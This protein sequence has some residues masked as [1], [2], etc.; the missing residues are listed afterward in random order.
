MSGQRVASRV[1][2]VVAAATL[3]LGAAGGAA[4]V[5]N[6]I[7]IGTHDGAIDEVVGLGFCYANGWAADPD[8]LGADVQ[9]RVVVD[10]VELVQ[11]PASEFRQDLLDAGIGDGTAAFWVDLTGSV[12]PGVPHEVRVQAQDVQTGAWVDVD[13]TPR[14][15][16]CTGL[17]GFHDTA[18]GAYMRRDCRVEGW[19]FDGDTPAARVRV[20]VRVDGRVV[21]DA[22]ADRFREDVRDAG[23]GDGFSG[24][25]VPLFGRM[26][27]NVPHRVVVEAR[28]TASR[29]TWLP[30]GDTGKP[31]T[32]YSS[33]Q[34]LVGSNIVFNGGAE[35]GPS[36][37]D[38]A[39]VIPAPGWTSTGN[40]TVGPY[41]ADGFP[42]STDPG[43]ADRGTNLFIGGPANDGSSF[44]Q[45]IA[46]GDLASA[47]DAE[48]LQYRLSAY[49]GG[50]LDQNDHSTVTV[51][52]RDGGGEA[53][54]QD[55]IGPVLA[56]DRAD[57]TGLE[58]RASSGDLPPGTR[59]IEVILSMVRDAPPEFTYN[60]G[61]AD[62][63]RLILVPEL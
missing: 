61:S 60:D 6:Q 35:L 40:A 39:A 27:P 37:G 46:V 32:C 49:L 11:L 26:S 55:S 16:T 59:S 48:A 62:N 51:I 52:F 23:F 44:S 9:V 34:S 45:V 19:A 30:L 21:A 29:Q 8:D 22:I 13:S 18:A 54:G 25:S 63:V 3:V 5:E 58:R 14:T 36:S 33:A 43:P 42:A 1:V 12:A 15:I 4:A 50:W 10:G 28:D 24:Y 2:A 53:L 7:P 57:M 20:R 31:M 17:A 38:W 47:I 41:D 56:S